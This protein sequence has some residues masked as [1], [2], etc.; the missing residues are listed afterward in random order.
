MYN[1]IVVHNGKLLAQHNERTQR[2]R[3]NGGRNLIEMQ[4]QF[5]IRS[6]Y[7]VLLRTQCHRL[8][9]C[10]FLSVHLENETWPLVDESIQKITKSGDGGAVG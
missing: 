9:P 4:L 3:L 10:D 2:K 5:H 1:L 6:K 8:R 7:N